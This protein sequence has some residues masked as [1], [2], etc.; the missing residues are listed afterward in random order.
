M[1]LAAALLAAAALAGADGWEGLAPQAAE[2]VL[3]APTQAGTGGMFGHILVVVRGERGEVS[4]THAADLGDDGT[5]TLAW[6]SMTWG[7]TARLELDPWPLQLRA[8]QQ[9]ER[10]PV[11]SY[12]L[13]LDQ[14]GLDRLLDAARESQRNPAP[15]HLLA[16]NCTRG[17]AELL[18]AAVPASGLAD[19]LGA[20]AM[21][22]DLLRAADHADLLDAGR[23]LPGP[24]D[25]G[26]DPLADP[27]AGRIALGG[28]SDDGDGYLEATLLPAWRGRDDAPSAVPAGDALEVLAASARWYHG[29]ERPV[30]QHATL[31]AVEAWSRRP[32]A[33]LGLGWAAAAEARRERR[34]T[35]GRG[36]LQPGVHGAYGPAWAPGT[37]SALW[38]AARVEGRLAD[39]ATRGTA[40]AGGECGAAA[41]AGP[42]RLDLRGRLLAWAGANHGSERRIQAGAAL[43]LGRRWSLRAQA[44]WSDAWE[45]E[46][47]DAGGDLRLH[48]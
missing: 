12:P 6:R 2:L 11:W 9:I 42:L 4:L 24:G 35:D 13:R 30:L 36:D 19:G 18:D 14:A 26:R 48:W 38:L 5:L 8:Y 43:A 20:W 39:D 17:I 22:A 1:K 16:A 37:E 46:A 10:R 34:G 32:A 15:Y 27:P 41:Y 3:A 29:A 44:T 31:I 28:G 40:G 21:P 7:Y 47:V 33:P 25:D 45:R 23:R